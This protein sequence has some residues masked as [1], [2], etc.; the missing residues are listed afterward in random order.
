VAIVREGY[1][2]AS[3]KPYSI[4]YAYSSES[5]SFESFKESIEICGDE[6][7]ASQSGVEVGKIAKL[8]SPRLN[9]KSQ[10]NDLIDML[11]GRKM[12]DAQRE[13]ESLLQEDD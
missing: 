4:H 2:K 9:K 5:N 3:L 12:L 8:D 10:F 1:A 11:N 7:V 6:V 13:L